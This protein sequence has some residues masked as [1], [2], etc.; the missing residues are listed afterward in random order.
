MGQARQQDM[1]PTCY[2]ALES[3]GGMEFSAENTEISLKWRSVDLK[4]ALEK[5]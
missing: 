5:E 4:Q 3:E 2:T 1:K